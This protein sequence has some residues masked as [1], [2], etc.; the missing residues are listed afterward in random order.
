MSVLE[1]K[2]SVFDSEM[3]VLDSEMYVPDSEMIVPESSTDIFICRLM[4]Y[5]SIAYGL[6]QD[7]VVCSGLPVEPARRALRRSAPCA[8]FLMSAKRAE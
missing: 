4:V 8:A 2:M 3:S 1:P 6:L 7:G 5:S